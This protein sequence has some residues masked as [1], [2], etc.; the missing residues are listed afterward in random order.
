MQGGKIPGV[1]L[2]ALRARAQ[3]SAE[4]IWA[5][6]QRSDALGRSAEALSPWSFCPSS[7]RDE[8]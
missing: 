6:W 5:G 2:E 1:D 4:R 8:R 3:A 7:A